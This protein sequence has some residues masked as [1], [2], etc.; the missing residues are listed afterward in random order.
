[1]IGYPP[2]V[3]QWGF[4]LHIK[5]RIHIVYILLVQL[6]PE[7]LHR[8]AEPLEM[9]HLPFPEE[10]DHIV[11]IRVIRQT[12]NVVVGCSGFLFCTHILHQIRD[13]IAFDL[14][15]GSGERSA[16]GSLRVNSHRMIHEVGRKGRVLDLTVLQIPCQ[17]M[18]DCA[19]HFQ[20]SQFL[21]TGR[22]VKMGPCQSQLWLIMPDDR[23]D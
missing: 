17:L 9:H 16:G 18:H 1:M 21:C 4:L 13:G 6:F 8:F 7:Q 12:Q 10:L 20:V 5:C 23:I 15:E 22:R 11:H 3:S 19:Y 2:L 14:E